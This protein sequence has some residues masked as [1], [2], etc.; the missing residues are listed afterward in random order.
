MKKL[1]SIITLVLV[2]F[3]AFSQ[4]P[5]LF[6]YQGV[7]RTTSGI[8]VANSVIGIR[9][10][11]LDGSVNGSILYTETQSPTTSSNGLFTVSIGAGKLV[12]GSI[13]TINWGTGT[14]F[15]KSEIDISG[16]TNYTLNNTSQLVSVP[17][18]QYAAKSGNGDV[19]VTLTG[20]GG[21]T[22]TGSYPSFSIN[23]NI[24][25]IYSAGY[26]LSLAGSSFSNTAPTQW[27]NTN[28][29]IAYLSGNLGIGTSNPA[30]KLHIKNGY[31]IIEHDKPSIVFSSNTYG[32]ANN[33]NW[34]LHLG[35]IGNGGL[36]IYTTSATGASW[37]FP[38]MHFETNGNIGVGTNSPTQKLHVENNG[39]CGIASI[40]YGNS[41]GERGYIF[42]GGGRGTR[43]SP[44]ALLTNDKLGEVQFWGHNGTFLGAAAAMVSVATENWNSTS[45][46]NRID[47]Y[48][49]QNGQAFGSYRMSIGNDG[50]IGIGTFT[51]K[52]KL[53]VSAG[54]IYLNDSSRGIILKSPNNSCWRVTIDN[55]GALVRTSITCP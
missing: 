3:L 27:L 42:L 48:T 16:G 52:S 40:G 36:E 13:S 22:I 38:V 49:C 44:Q 43:S 18:A 50:N 24:A 5:N 14:K 39:N 46:G 41:T 7:A 32:I 8:P 33:Q 47:F 31:E 11:I 34:M 1:F 4:A 19:P 2:N 54:D 9:L 45:Y 51:A 20:T 12:S 55:T 30:Q 53:E 37:G 23:S 17:Y 26:G 35:S 10:S 28:S 21:T 25:N 6:N 29:G 15:L